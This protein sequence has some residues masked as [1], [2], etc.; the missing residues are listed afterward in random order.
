MSAASARNAY[1][2]LTGIALAV[3]L[4]ALMVPKEFFQMIFGVSGVVIFIIANL[5][6][7]I[8]WRCPKCRKILPLDGMLGATY[9]S[10]C[11]KEI[12]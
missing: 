7:L 1:F 11:G 6:L 2:A 3:E 10:C 5:L 8:F 4:L 12:Y 9:C